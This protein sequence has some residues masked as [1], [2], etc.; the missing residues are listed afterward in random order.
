MNL[1]SFEKVWKGDELYEIELKAE[2]E[3]IKIKTKSYADPEKITELAERLLSFPQKKND[4]FLWENGIKG[5]GYTPCFSLE[6]ECD[7]RGRV[8]IEVYSEID[9]GASFEKHNCCFF[10]E[11][12]IGLVNRFGKSLLNMNNGEIGN[13]AEM[14]TID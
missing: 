12:E 1:L 13:K 11:S 14:K 5:D 10:I 4:R 3:F 9:D 7:E 6:F 2:S 8:K